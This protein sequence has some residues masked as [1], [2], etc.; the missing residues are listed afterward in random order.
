[1]QQLGKFKHKNG[2]RTDKQFGD[3]LR[4]LQVSWLL[5]QAVWKRDIY[6]L[7]TAVEQRALMTLVF[8]A[9]R[10]RSSKVRHSVERQSAADDCRCTTIVQ[11]GMYFSVLESG[12]PIYVRRI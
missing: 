9:D 1:M 10:R 3:C 2:L 5:E 8:V 12:V 11:H 4:F 6:A 7:C